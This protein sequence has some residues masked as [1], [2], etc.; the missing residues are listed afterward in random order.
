[1]RP[2]RHRRSSGQMPGVV[3]YI[4]MPLLLAVICGGLLY[5]G[6]SPAA[7]GL[8]RMSGLL[9][10]SGSEY[11]LGDTAPVI[12]EA[13]AGQEDAGADKPVSET[14]P[15]TAPKQRVEEPNVGDAYGTLTCER[16]N[17]NSTVYFGDNSDVLLQGIGTYPVSW[18]PGCGH[19]T[20][21]S[22]HNDMALATLG[23][24]AV[25]DRFTL[26]TNY[27]TFEYR[28]SDIKIVD[29]TETEACR[30]DSDTEQVVLYTCYPFYRISGRRTERFF[31]YL[32]KLSGPEI[33]L[34]NY[35]LKD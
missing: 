8:R 33:E 5:A 10:N 23:D 32:E 2:T 1:M 27:G 18:I 26:T 4:C 3:A 14:E 19:T 16:L 29:E 17:I 7:E 13:L 22:G 11:F 35:F 25:D 6:L 20:L 28:V 24:V 21:M 12:R 34:F 30:L 31:V 9:M 15:E